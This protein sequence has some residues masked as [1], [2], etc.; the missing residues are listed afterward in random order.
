MVVAKKKERISRVVLE[1]LIKRRQSP[2]LFSLSLSLS[3]SLSCRRERRF[4]RFVRV[5]GCDV[6]FCYYYRSSTTI[7]I[8]MFLQL[9]TEL[10]KTLASRRPPA[11]TVAKMLHVCVMQTEPRSNDCRFYN[12]RSDVSSVVQR[13]CETETFPSIGIHCINETP[14]NAITAL[15]HSRPILDLRKTDQYSHVFLS[16]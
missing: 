8:V 3:L 2:S 9:Q 11:T 16:A 4:F 12:V 7:V 5:C 10:D 13:E 15:A 14:L 1:I 6:L